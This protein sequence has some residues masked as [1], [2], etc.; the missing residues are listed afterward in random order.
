MIYTLFKP[1]GTYVER[2]KWRQER[3][4]RG[5]WLGSAPILLST[6]ELM[7]GDVLFCGSLNGKKIGNTIRIA[8]AGEYVHCALYI[9]QGR[10]VDVVLSGAR[11]MRIEEFIQQYSYVA[12]TRCPGNEENSDRRHKLMEFGK[13]ISATD[14]KRVRYNFIGA[15]LVIFRELSDLK[16]LDFLWQKRIQPQPI[17]KPVERM[18]C[19]ELVINAYIN[20]GYISQN[21]LFIQSGRR[22]PNGLAEENIFDFIGYMSIDGWT[23]IS[24]ND[25][26]LSGCGWVITQEGRDRLERSEN[27]LFS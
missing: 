5:L 2:W 7:A 24:K 13:S 17:R 22:T 16:K 4:I 27:D 6:S 26:F 10:V 25:H 3:K 19:S 21:D 15:G 18:F 12:V 23:A 1:L 9:G 14:A 8:T 20:C 11:S